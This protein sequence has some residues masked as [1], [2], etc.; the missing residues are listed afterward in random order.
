MAARD[1]P[2]ASVGE[3]EIPGARGALGRCFD[4]LAGDPGLDEA[5]RDGLGEVERRLAVGMEAEEVAVEFSRHVGTDRKAARV[6]A[7]AD[8]GPERL[9]PNPSLDEGLDRVGGDLLARSAPAAMKKRSSR[10]VLRHDRD[11]SA[12][13]GRD[14]HPGIECSQEK[15][16][17]LARRLAR[18]D[19]H[20]TMD[21]VNPKR[22]ALLESG[23]L[24]QPAPVLGHRYLVVADAEAEIQGGVGTAADASHAA[25]HPEPGARWKGS[26]AGLP[27]GNRLRSRMRRLHGAHIALRALAAQAVC[28]G[29]LLS[30]CAHA[31]APA[32]GAEAR[33]RFLDLY[34][35]EDSATRGAGM[36]SIER[37]TVG[38]KGLNATWAA[39][40]DSIALA[41]YVGP[42]RSVDAALL[43]DSLYLAMRRYDLVL[44]GPLPPEKGLGPRGLLFLARPWTFDAPWV[45]AALERST[46][47]PV[48]GG[49]RISGVLDSEQGPHPFRLELN[50]K[51]DP[52]NLLVEPA[53]EG[54]IRLQIRYG[55]A[56]RFQDARIPRWIEWT[57]L[58]APGKDGTRIRLDIED[59]ARA[60]PSQFRHPPA[61]NAEWEVVALDDPEGRELL[62]RW[63]GVG[64]EEQP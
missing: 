51:L 11:G 14:G 53:R 36:L 40:A 38:R 28:A 62:R 2:I 47:E 49:W 17:R 20:A 29:F 55:P 27:D 57:T 22:P 1:S 3:V 48:K 13:R 16:V 54:G 34:G 33:A 39:S 60:K 42:V 4:V 31:P 5:S 10:R 18:F 26:G 32:G 12:V 7:R 23:R 25:S 9:R 37:G 35:T 56:R 52:K 41:A 58:P 44:A 61:P 30:G 8:D 50:S 6:Q 19:E 45:R 24:T 43:G 15:P 64:E 46:V 59:H 21:L 63:F